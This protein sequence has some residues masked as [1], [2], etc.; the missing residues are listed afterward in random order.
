VQLGYYTI[1]APFAG[2]VG[3]IPVKVGDF[4]NTSTL[5]ATLTENKPLEVNISVPIELGPQLRSGMPVQ[6][7]N[8]QGRS[9]GTSRVFFISPNTATNTQ[10]ILVKALFDNAKGQLRAD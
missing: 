6:L 8:D 3:N 9:I 5:L 2:T 7:L 10:S 4:V 1:N